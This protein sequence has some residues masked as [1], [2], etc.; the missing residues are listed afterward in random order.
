[1]VFTNTIYSRNTFCI[2]EKK[3]CNK[4]RLEQ[5]IADIVVIM[6]CAYVGIKLYNLELPWG[7]NRAFRYIPFYMIG[8]YSKHLP[9]K[10]KEIGL[11]E[12]IGIGALTVEIL[13][14]RIGLTFQ[15]WYYI[16]ACFGICFILMLAILWENCSILR[17]MGQNSLLLFVMHGP[18]YRALLGIITIISGISISYMRNSIWISLLVSTVVV[19]ILVVPIRMINKYCPWMAG[20]ILSF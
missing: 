14:Y 5:T 16:I 8:F 11:S 13:M 12:I 1:M 17:Y 3:F 19:A 6:V 20:K 4:S 9:E 18:L 2:M 15:I 10:V 7:L